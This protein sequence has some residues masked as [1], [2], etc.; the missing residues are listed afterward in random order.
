MPDRLAMAMA[1]W[2][3]SKNIGKETFCDAHHSLSAT[4]ALNDEGG[5]P[6]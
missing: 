5:N 3:A 6:V 2:V 4:P 1:K